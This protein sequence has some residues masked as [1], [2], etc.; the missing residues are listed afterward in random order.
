LAQRNREPETIGS[1]LPRILPKKGTQKLLASARRKWRAVV[2]EPI[3]S[4]TNVDS[5]EYGTL[6]INVASSALLSDL[7]FAR[8]DIIAEMRE[9]DDAITLKE[10]VFSLRRKDDARRKQG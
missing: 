6:R 8:T 3:A 4:M 2:G 1:I 9:G 5:L 10:V 7:E